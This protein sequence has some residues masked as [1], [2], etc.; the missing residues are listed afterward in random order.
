LGKF[1]KLGSMKRFLC[2]M[3][4]RE[5]PPAGARLAASLD[6]LLSSAMNACK[7]HGFC[8]KSARPALAVGAVSALER[9]RYDRINLGVFKVPHRVR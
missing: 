7:G 9:A 5:V 8:A 3:P 1:R 2:Q 4:V 6:R